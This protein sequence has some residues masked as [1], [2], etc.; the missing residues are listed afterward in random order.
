MSAV[1]GTVI[2]KP[3]NMLPYVGKLCV[4]W[5]AVLA[6]FLGSAFGIPATET[7]PYKWRAVSLCGL[8]M[9]YG[10]VFLISTKHSAVKARTTILGLAMQ[11]ILGLLVFKVSTNLLQASYS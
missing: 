6:L 7:S 4:G 9:L 8:V 11:Q 2:E 3:W 1:W 10:F 5:G